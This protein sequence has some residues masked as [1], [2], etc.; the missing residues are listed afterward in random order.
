MREAAF[1]RLCHERE[2]GL[3]FP[4]LRPFLLHETRSAPNLREPEVR[5]RVVLDGEP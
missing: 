2:I 5:S 1:E 3:S 4:W